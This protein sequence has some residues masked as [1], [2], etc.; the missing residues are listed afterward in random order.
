MSLRLLF[1][2]DTSLYG[3]LL[4][5]LII[6]SYT[7]QHFLPCIIV[8]KKHI[9]RSRHLITFSL[10]GKRRRG[11][12]DDQRFMA[13]MMH[14]KEEGKERRE[15]PSGLYAFHSQ[16]PPYAFDKSLPSLL[17]LISMSACCGWN[18]E[19]LTLFFSSFFLFSSSRFAHHL[20]LHSMCNLIQ[21]PSRNMNITCSLL[22]FFSSSLSFP[23]TYSAIE[24]CT[25][26]TVSHISFPV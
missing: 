22:A 16:N 26:S 2:Q 9:P 6:S 21:F 14:K 7:L 11:R 12:G 17:Y 15:N 5:Y 8:L 4:F 20:F 18:V 13:C 1:S 23:L 3:F 19:G 10:P 24:I 25:D